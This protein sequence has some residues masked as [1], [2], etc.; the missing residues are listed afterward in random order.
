VNRLGIIFVLLTGLLKAQDP[1]YK[2]YSLKDGLPSRETYHIIS[3]AKGLLWI[4]TDAGLCQSNGYSFKTF[5]T[6][7]GLPE[8]AVLRL[9]EDA[10]GRIWFSTISSHVGYVENGKIFIIKYVFKEPLAKPHVSLISSFCVD[11]GDTLWLGTVSLKGLL[12]KIP[13][14]Y[15]NTVSIRVE[16]RNNYVLDFGTPGAFIYGTAMNSLS[17]ASIFMKPTGKARRFQLSRPSD[18]LL[19]NT[20]NIFCKYND[21]VIFLSCRTSLYKITNNK[22][23]VFKIFKKEICA[24]SKDANGGFWCGG[25]S[26]GVY[27][28]ERPLTND[29]PEHFFDEV[30]ITS[31]VCDFEGGYWF[32]SLE[33][34]VLYMPYRDLKCIVPEIKDAKKEPFSFEVL[35]KD[36]YAIQS[37]Y[38]PLY[39]IDH[40][41]TYIIENDGA[42]IVR[43]EYDPGKLYYCGRQSSGYIDLRNNYM[44]EILS[45]RGTRA[46]SKQMY[47][48][49]N[50]QVYGI[51]AHGIFLIK[52]DKIVR[53]VLGIHDRIN[54][55]ALDRKN[56]KF[57]MVTRSGLYSYTERDSLKYEGKNFP[58]SAKY[59]D[60]INIDDRER[61][62]IGQKGGN[63]LVLD[64]NSSIGS[65]YREI[66]LPAGFSKVIYPDKDSYTWVSTKEGLV[67]INADNFSVSNYSHLGKFISSE[68]NDIKRSGNVLYLITSA[69]IFAIEV[70]SLQ[71]KTKGLKVPINI[72]KVTSIQDTI[73]P[74]GTVLDH[75][76]NSLTFHFLT[77]SYLNAGQLVYRYKLAG[78]DS[79]WRLTTNQSVEYFN[80]PPGKFKFLLSILPVNESP[81]PATEFMFEIWPPFWARAW[82]I[83]FEVGVVL[84]AFYFFFRIRT[85]QIK[86][87]E[88]EKTKVSIFLAGMEARWLRTQMNPHFIFNAMNAIQ[89]FIMKSDKRMAN[90]YLTKF[91]MLIRNIL[92]YSQNDFIT[93]TREIESLNLYMEL[94]KLRAAGRFDYEITIGEELKKANLSVPSMLIQPIVENAIIHGVA[95]LE[96]R[97]GIIQVSF[98]RQDTLIECIVEDNGVGRQ[99]ASEIRA[100][101]QSSH[102]SMGITITSERLNILK[103][104]YGLDSSFSIEDLKG[105][106]NSFCGTKVTLLLPFKDAVE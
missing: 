81:P 106:D 30:T 77:L 51:I 21:S 1:V 59:M 91:A 25:L 37:Y 89:H 94:E 26:D 36:K 43:S 83:V 9:Y 49:K 55:C 95:L 84:L 39:I 68:I 20:K 28:F 24:L 40:H 22:I 14:P 38:G 88:Q 105:D 15:T 7:N 44:K 64:P 73:I 90:T 6:R 18:S 96:N 74:R 62:W 57:W 46:P 102:K 32:S 50:G 23:K 82:F 2:N 41:R 29:A 104:M 75:D 72:E 3:D 5:T 63:I 60:K 10:K 16:M 34:G 58:V 93:L 98:T 54:S 42:R 99:K 71:G 100:G 17:Q 48:D 8:N 92:E 19:F 87:N 86:R 11:E 33:K 78:L 101:K 53:H 27:Y 31:A 52:D 47:E 61:L 97:K 76:H 56:G 4:A 80:L 65:N 45:N 13:P 66:V 70:S 67:S 12:F 69:G 79:N 85:R 35:A 103:K